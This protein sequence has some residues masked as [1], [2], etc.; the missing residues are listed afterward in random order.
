[1]KGQVYSMKFKGLIS[2][3]LVAAC[4]LSF[5]GCY[6]LPDE[7]EVLEAPT[8]KASDVTYTTVTAKRK[9]IEKKLTGSGTVMSRSTT[10]LSF[11]NQGGTIKSINVKAGDTVQ[12]GDVICELD[13][14]NLEYEIKDKELKIQQAQLNVQIV[15]EGGGTQ[16]EVDNAQV[17]VEILQNE[18]DELNAEMT[19][20]V[21]YSDIDGTV[22]SISDLEAGST[23]SAGEAIATVID[24]NSLYMAFEPSDISKYSIGQQITIT[25][26]EVDYTGEVFATST[27]FPEDADVT[28]E[29]DRVYVAFTG[30]VPSDAVGNIADAVLVLDSRENVIAIAK[31]FIKSVGDKT[32]V[33]V[34]NDNNEK[35]AREVETGLE[36]GSEV[37]IVSGLSEGEKIIVR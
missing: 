28:Y 14:G 34:L 29:K 1:M 19:E 32:V 33:Y 31:K 6:F 13:T 10:E 26:N 2:A 36:T 8:V 20:S 5:S 30:E 18:L 23:V 12:A 3:A 15:A 24:K 27:D 9:N 16:A 37:E 4:A 22:S 35:E 11:K 17:S 21:L 25:Y 7:E